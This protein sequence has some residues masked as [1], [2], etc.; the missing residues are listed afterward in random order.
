MKAILKD[1]GIDETLTKTVKKI[2]GEQYFTNVKSII[3]EK[4]DYNFAMDVLI[5]PETKDKY[6]GLLV[7]VDLATD[8][9]D[10]E[11]IKSK[12]PKEILE[13]FKKMI[14]RKYIKKPEYTL[15]TDAGTEFK[16]IFQNYLFHNNIYH[17]T[18]MPG[19]H[20]QNANVE[21]LNRELGRLI[22]GYLNKIENET[23]HKSK[24]WLPIIPKIRTK[25]NE[26]RNKTDKIKNVNY[27]NF[28]PKVQLF[29]KT[30]DKKT[31]DKEPKFKVGDL[32]HRREYEAIDI[33]GKKEYGGSKRVGDYRWS[34]LPFKI[35][36]IYIYP[37]PIFYRYKLD[38]LKNNGSTFT[39]FELKKSKEKERKYIISK[40][41]DT[42]I[43]QKKR[44]YKVQYKNLPIENNIN[45]VWTTLEE[46]GLTEQ[47]VKE[48]IDDMNETKKKKKKKN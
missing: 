19:K 16:G 31:V 45:P 27:K 9:F 47:D 18:T 1:L 2:K 6:I 28:V 38:D 7:C 3:P 20:T 15:R 32:V 21:R 5:L 44:Y 24:E 35:T 30:D 26:F 34:R 8:E 41:L 39:E 11:P 17:S 36:N 29:N 12:N 25:L 40:I 46:I 4:S 33:Y 14:T 10:I 42:F 23:G 43:K 37:A 48:F 22:I 13:A